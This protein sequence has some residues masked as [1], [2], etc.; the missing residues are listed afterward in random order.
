MEILLNMFIGAIKIK[1]KV[2]SGA[3]IISIFVTVS[4]TI[5]RKGIL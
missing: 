1:P 3:L 2:S 4:Y 5:N